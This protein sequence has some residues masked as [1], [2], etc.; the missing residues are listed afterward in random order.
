MRVLR[1]VAAPASMVLLRE[2][3][4]FPVEEPGLGDLLETI[5]AIVADLAD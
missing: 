3:G 2:C 4:H 1:R 5:D